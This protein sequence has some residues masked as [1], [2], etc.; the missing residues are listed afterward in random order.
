[1]TSCWNRAGWRG[2]VSSTGTWHP[3]PS[4]DSPEVF[5]SQEQYWRVS[6]AMAR[7]VVSVAGPKGQLNPNCQNPMLDWGSNAFLLCCFYLPTSHPALLGAVPCI[8]CES[9]V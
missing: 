6:P 4:G 1:M 9:P 3:A 2:R 7:R 8:A 5:L